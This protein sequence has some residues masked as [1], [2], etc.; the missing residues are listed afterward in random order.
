[1]VGPRTDLL[2][3]VDTRRQA[4]GAF[5]R[6]LYTIFISFPRYLA[7]SCFVGRF[8]TDTT[9][10]NQTVINKGLDPV[11]GAILPINSTLT[12]LTS[13]VRIVRDI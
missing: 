9:T 10:S 2:T 7:R 1:M 5:T 12:L 8:P 13:P 3:K 11:G 6:A 4:I